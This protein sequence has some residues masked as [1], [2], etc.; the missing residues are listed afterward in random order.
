VRELGATPAAQHHSTNSLVPKRL[1]SMLFQA[2]SRRTGR[3]ST[4]PTPSSQL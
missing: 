2:R 4:G 1:L 3:S